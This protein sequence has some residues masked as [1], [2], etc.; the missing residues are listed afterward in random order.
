[1]KTKKKC[2]V[3]TGASIG[4]SRQEVEEELLDVMKER[5]REW[6]NAN[7][8]DRGFARL[9]FRQSVQAFNAVVLYAEGP[10]GRVMSSE[11]DLLEPQLTPREAQ[12]LEK[13]AMGL[14][15]NE[16]AIELNISFKT[17]VTHRSHLMGKF[18]VGNMALLI[19]RAIAAGYIMP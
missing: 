6:I 8:Q 18:K 4:K 19:R 9:R 15:S 3:P 7:P 14:T 5:R 2:Q 16:I 1:M 12:V 13:I 17:A 10:E 11:S